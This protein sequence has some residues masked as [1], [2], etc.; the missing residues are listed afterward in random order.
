MTDPIFKHLVITSGLNKDF[1]SKLEFL[2][3]LDYNTTIKNV[4]KCEKNVLLEQKHGEN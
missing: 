2:N 4:I 3:N 1:H